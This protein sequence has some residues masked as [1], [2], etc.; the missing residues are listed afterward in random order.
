MADDLPDQEHDARVQA[1]E[2]LAGFAAELGAFRIACGAPAMRSLAST[3]PGMSLS[4]LSEIFSGKRLPSIDVTVRVV[5]A[6]AEHA[7]PYAAHPEGQAD[8]VEHHIAEWRA[9]WTKAKELQSTADRLARQ[10]RAATTRAA[11]EIIAAAHIEAEQ[12][13]ETGK[14]QVERMIDG[15]H[16]EAERIV[17]ATR[18]GSAKDAAIQAARA[19]DAIREEAGRITTEAREKAA[20]RL[21]TA[22]RQ[23][24]ELVAQARQEAQRLRQDAASDA[25]ALKASAE[26][27]ASAV[28]TKA[29]VEVMK[30]KAEAQR[31]LDAL[32]RRRDAIIDEMARVDGVLR[33]L[34]FAVTAQWNGTA[35]PAPAPAARQASAERQH[36]ESLLNSDQRAAMISAAVAA[37]RAEVNGRETSSP[38]PVVFQ[39]AMEEPAPAAR[40]KKPPAPLEP[41]SGPESP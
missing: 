25:A 27:H 30:A 37:A 20:A 11:D 21:Q 36:R 14:S 35:A 2:A 33:V 24:D 8:T 18:A 26:R 40:R 16:A 13:R 19:E 10:A 6:M 3:T 38:T 29:M 32:S 28:A 17:S 12:I 15:A 34:N 1:A 4:N 5:R 23:A 39:R 22:A 7:A 31:D 41:P 9:R